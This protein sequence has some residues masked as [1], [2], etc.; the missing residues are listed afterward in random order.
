MTRVNKE[1]QLETQKRMKETRA[2]DSI[3]LRTIIDNK[4]KWA[5]AER[6][7]GV[8][9]IGKLETQIEDT[10]ATVLRLEGCISS[11]N[12]VLTESK[13]HAEGAK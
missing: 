11:L 1:K 5:Q 2:Q 13:T 9:V 4:I 7:K 8:E 3:H 12:Q 10:K 6:T